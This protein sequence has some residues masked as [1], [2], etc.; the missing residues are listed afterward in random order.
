MI[1][2][3]VRSFAHHKAAAVTTGLVAMVGTA[4][5]TAMAGLLGTGLSSDTAVGDRDFL[6]RFPLILGGWVLAI[7]V[8]AMVSTIGV[9]L[10]GRAGEIAGIRLVGATPSQVRRMV[11]AETAVVAAIAAVPGLGGGQLLGA[12]LLAGIRGTGLI[13]DA[14]GYFPGAALPLIGAASMLGASIAAAWI[15]SRTI[16]SR[17][18][19]DDPSPAR[20]RG[21][22]GRARPIAAISVLIAGLASSFTVLA[23]DPADILTT[24]LTGPG[25]VLVAVG[26]SLLAPE[27]I[28]MA[29]FVFGK[30]PA[31]RAGAAGHLTALNLAAAPERVRP[32][33]TFLTLFIGV[34][35]GTLSMQ[36]IE[37]DYGAEGGDG[38]LLAAINYLVVVL[39]AAF[40]AIALSN[41]LVASI[42][43]RHTEFVSMHLIG[44]TAT[45]SRRM[46]ISEAT[47]AVTVSA[48]AGGLGAFA[49]TAPFAITKTGDPLA[50]LAPLPYAVSIMAGAVITLSVTALAGRRMINTAAA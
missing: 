25:C 4:L 18:P 15:G 22:T 50:A 7:V 33:V 14:T 35:A 23:I 32:A 16:A 48:V 47:A 2:L 13:D 8:F 34:A 38:Q 19:V 27:L 39:I 29:E 44:A 26:A 49:S 1:G 24:A 43:R 6:V 31:L 10:Q 37:N 11:V 40:M 30:V 46:L 12:G 21:R 20:V 9:A 42:A 28:T 41:N 17:S 36:G 5:V 45:Q 3:A